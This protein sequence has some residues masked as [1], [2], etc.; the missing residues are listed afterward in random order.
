MSLSNY[1]NVEKSP[2]CFKVTH[3]SAGALDQGTHFDALGSGAIWLHSSEIRKGG[4]EGRVYWSRKRA[5]TSEQKG[6]NSMS[7][8]CAL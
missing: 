5:H 6:V 2:M 1:E 3:P 8:I 4:G 7:Y